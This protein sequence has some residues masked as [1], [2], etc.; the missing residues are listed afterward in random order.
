ME[1]LCL[2]RVDQTELIHRDEWDVLVVLDACRFD[3]FERVYPKYLSG[4]LTKVWSPGHI[5]PAWLGKTWTEWYDVTYVSA[6]PRVNT[7]GIPWVGFDAMK[8][9]AK[10][11]DAWNFAWDKELS[12]V[13]PWSMTDIVLETEGR[14]VAHYVQPHVPY[15][16]E[17]KCTVDTT[18]WSDARWEKHKKRMFSYSSSK[19]RAIA[20]KSGKPE[21]LRRAYEDNLRCALKEVVRLVDG[22]DRRVV[23]TSDHGEFLGEGNKWLH[24]P[25]WVGDPIIHEVPW[26]EADGTVSTF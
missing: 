21:F 7:F 17:T 10:V 13:P 23:V 4:T 24:K 8:R 6:N 20:R 22:T 26:F 5:T 12:T 15:I 25:T 14:V 11:V 16:G 1:R 3:V 18:T 19:T 2:K 9:F